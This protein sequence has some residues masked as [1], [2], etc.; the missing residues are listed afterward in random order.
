MKAQMLMLRQELIRA[1]VS[2]SPPSSAFRHDLTGLN[3]IV[4]HC[5]YVCTCF[6]YLLW[7]LDIDMSR[8]TAEEE[9]EHVRATVKAELDKAKIENAELAK[10]PTSAVHTCLSTC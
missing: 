5:E 10:V 7:P 8:P 3:S 4:R 1:A 6:S 9:L 2:G